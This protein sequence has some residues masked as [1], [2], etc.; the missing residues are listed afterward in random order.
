MRHR[1][2]GG[3]A[4]RDGVALDAPRLL[5]DPEVHPGPPGRPGGRRDRPAPPAVAAAAVA[6]ADRAAGD[7]RRPRPVRPAEA[8]PPD[9]RDPPDREQPVALPP[10]PRAD[11]AA[12]GHRGVRRRPGGVHRRIDRQPGPGGVRDRLPAAVRVHRRGAPQRR[13]GRPAPAAP[14]RVHAAARGPVRRRPDPVRLGPVPAGA[15]AD[16]ADRGVAAGLHRHP[17]EGEGVLAAGLHRGAARLEPGEAGEHQPALVRGGPPPVSAG[18]GT[19]HQRIGRVSL[20]VDVDRT[21]LLADPGSPQLP[22]DLLA[23]VPAQKSRQPTVAEHWLGRT[24]ERGFPAYAMSLRGHGG[25]G[26]ADRRRKTT[27]REYVHDVMQVAASLPRRAVLVGHGVGGLV[28]AQVLARYPAQA[29][30]LVAP[31]TAGWRGLGSALLRH[32][33]GTL[34]GA[35]GGSVGLRGGQLFS[36]GMAKDAVRRYR[37][38]LDPSAPRVQY[39]LLFRRRLEPALPVTSVLVVGSG[40]DRLVGQRALQ[41]VASRY[42]TEPLLFPGMGHDMMLDVRWA[43]PIDAILDWLPEA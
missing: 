7:R 6:D 42:G 37:S 35:F 40:Q 31:M 34:P 22:A 41:K 18:P 24:A 29:G 28:V 38:R 10:R 43:E 32:P 27:I 11:H 5:A 3:A 14:A 9:L 30:V 26:G 1:G 17:G 39:Q 23:R 20:H 15:L 21:Q 4:G 36:R 19:H 25:S 12:A 16:G 13:P 8:R 33:F 2:R